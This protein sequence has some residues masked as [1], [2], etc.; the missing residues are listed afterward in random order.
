M[1]ATES[2]TK[3]SARGDREIVITREFDAPRELVFKAITDPT[4]I[5]KW[6]GPRRYE[7]IVDKMD[8]RPGGAW[9]FINRAADGGEHGFNGVYREIVPP[10]KIVQ[11][12]EWEGLPGHISVETLILEDLGGRTRITTT[13]VFDT[14]EDRDG[15]M[16]SGAESGA[17]ET[18]ERFAE[19]L[20]GLKRKTAR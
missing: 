17:R 5:P 16:Q 15:M 14:K 7:T 8:V 19:V 13:S 4:L 2:S 20:E 10:E 1:P 11:T 3:F 6:W 18:W 12:F 9:R